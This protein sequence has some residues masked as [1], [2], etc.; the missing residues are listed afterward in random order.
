MNPAFIARWNVQCSEPAE[1]MAKSSSEA[2]AAKAPGSAEDGRQYLAHLER[3]NSVYYDQIKIADQ[4]AAFIFTFMLAFLVSSAEGSSVF[5]IERYQTGTWALVVLLGRPGDRGR[6]LAGQRDPG[7]AAAPPASRRRRSTGAPG[8]P[9]ATRSSR[10]MMARDPDYLFKRISEQRRQSGRHQPLEIPPCRP[11]V[12]R[13]DHCR[14]RLS[15][16]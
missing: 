14:A 13:A 1:R 11:C 12:S 15:R 3:I 16:C 5:R 6:V 10:R 7:G 8:R 4:K 9:I 2:D